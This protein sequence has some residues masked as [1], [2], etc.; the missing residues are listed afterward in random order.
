MLQGLSLIQA[1][2][3]GH[4]DVCQQLL[5]AGA[6]VNQTG[7]EG[8][9]PLMYAASRGHIEACQQL[10][11]AGATVDQATTW[12]MTPLMA[13]AQDGHA[14]ICSLLLER[15]ADVNQVTLNGITALRKAAV[16]G[17]PEVCDLLLE[18]NKIPNDDKKKVWDI[19]NRKHNTEIARIIGSHIDTSEYS[20]AS[21]GYIML[22]DFGIFQKIPES[23][24]SKNNENVAL[25]SSTAHSP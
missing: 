2:R 14:R 5:D 24:K 4:A 15:G 20:V 19:V 13:A 9:T 21:N 17:Y 10:L 23:T 18:T 6:N 1:A 25:L 8:C 7:A 3:E 16:L 22:E 12:G 11:N